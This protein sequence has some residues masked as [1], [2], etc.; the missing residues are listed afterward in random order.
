MCSSDLESGEQ[1]PAVH[2]RDYAQNRENH[3]ENN[4]DSNGQLDEKA[5]QVQTEQKNQCAGDG[6]KR[7][8]VLAEKSADSAGGRAERDEDRGKS[9]NES[10]RRREQS[11]ARRL[12]LAQLFHA[13]A[14]EH[15]NVSGHERQNA[16]GQE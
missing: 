13:D 2:E 16:R 7:G 5:E 6:R 11:G 1:R 15:G 14:G 4:S 10:E 12:A 9:E 8:A 3:T